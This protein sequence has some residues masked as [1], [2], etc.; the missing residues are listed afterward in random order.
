[1]IN[2]ILNR[3]MKFF[4]IGL[5]MLLGTAG[6]SSAAVFDLQT[7]AI[8]KTMPDATQIPMWGFGLQGGA[9]T[10]PGPELVVPPGD[11]TLTINLQNNLTVP[12]S[13]IIP[14]L[15]PAPGD[16]TPVRNPDGRV[17]SFVKETSPGGA[18]T[19]T[20]TVKPGTYL[21]QSGS[22]QQIQIPMGLYGAVKNDAALGQA[23]AGVN[24]SQDKVILFS[25]I[26]P[27]INNAVATGNYGPGLAV[28]S[29]IDYTARYFLI[30]GTPFSAGAPPLLTGSV[31]QNILLRF[32]N[33]GVQ[34]YV[35]ILQGVYMTLWAED[36]NKFSFPKKQY[37]LLLPAGKTLDALINP[38]L[39]GSIPLYDRRLNL[40]NR[41]TSPGGLLTFIQISSGNPNIFNLV[42]QYYNNI[43]DRAPEP[44]GAEGWTAEIERIV[45]LGIDIKEGFI[46][47]GKSFFNSAEYLAMAK[48]DAA[49]V[50][51]LY[52]TF[53]QRVPAQA[54][55]DYWVGYLTTGMSR[56]I[57]LNYFVYSPE[58]NAYMTGIFGVS[59]VR[60]ENNL[61]NDFYRG[62]LNRLP[63]TAGF[64]AWFGLMRAAQ[65]TGAQQ[66]RD[67]SNQI[68]L[69]FIQSA[70]YGLRA[71]TNS[72]YVEDLYDAIL[73]RGALPAEV[74]YWVTFLNTA[75]REETLPFFTGSAEFYLSVTEVINAG[76]LP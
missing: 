42:V 45:S 7:G 72:Q 63:D 37:S 57:A 53:L 6:L 62:I 4:L 32:L 75:T 27:V 13:I 41:L 61:V 52:E 8:T 28:S 26:D 21:Y 65:C 66:V 47:A 2:M 10:V 67:L 18:S 51:D 38:T 46:A 1:M 9:V 16:I 14:G 68:A 35:P 12:V 15:T 30:N 24:Y 48:T 58:F 3:S 34:D 73:R 44:G 60:P 39:S 25:E 76:C 55:I 56:N 50:T 36:G 40:T 29:I 11:T 69:G 64:N 49:Y 59:L 43:L 74:S 20:F 23:Y 71:R 22:H 70:E 19:Y 33:A 5:V 54:E 31:G 17:R